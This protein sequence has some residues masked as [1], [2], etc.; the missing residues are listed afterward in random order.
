M[1]VW[2]TAIYSNDTAQ[3]LRDLCQ[4]VYAYYG[5]ENLTEAM[6]IIKKE[7]SYY[8]EDSC[9]IDGDYADFW[10]AFADWHWKH[11][12][13]SEEHRIKVLGILENKV[14]ML[15]WEEAGNSNDIQKRLDVMKKLEEELNGEMPKTKLP[16][17]NQKKPLHKP[18]DVIIIK[19]CSEE[20]DSIPPAAREY[21]GYGDWMFT[22]AEISDVFKDEK[23]KYH[24]ESIR[25]NENSY[26]NT[27]ICRIDSPRPIK[28][29]GEGVYN[30]DTPIKLYDKY[31]AFLCVGEGLSSRNYRHVPDVFDRV[32][33]YAIYDIISDEKPSL[34]DLKKCGF[35]PAFQYYEMDG[36]GQRGIG[37]I[38]QIAP[39]SFRQKNKASH[40][41]I[42]I[43]SCLEE[44]ERF[45]KLLRHKNYMEKPH[46]DD[47]RCYSI[48]YKSAYATKLVFENMGIKLD[49]LLDENIRIPETISKEEYDARR[50]K[51]REMEEFA[52]EQIKNKE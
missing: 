23:L 35:L 34:D 21:H 41:D 11:G 48:Y 33:I 29:S 36:Y 37:Y 52:I 32:S 31:V 49:N 6:N 42:E 51:R 24:F 43:V 7:F 20:E 2:G 5:A 25:V 27:P 40:S 9:L 45:F 50:F 28:V 16:R 3:D 38:N 15:E 17:F 18:G 46:F 1:G 13:L 12:I 39:W 44:A 4:E 30:F 47:Y 22:Y 19:T 26:F 8:F 10:Y 14:G